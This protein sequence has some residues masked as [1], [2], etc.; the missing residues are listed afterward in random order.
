MT[1]R[2]CIF[3]MH[4]ISGVV[5]G[6][7]V[8]IMSVTGVL[9]TYE[10]QML[11]QADRGSYRTP[12]PHAGASR[13]TIEEVL[14]KV[15][16]RLPRGA[17]VTV[18]SGADEPVEIAAGR[19]G[20]LYVNPWTG[21]VLGGSAD[22][23][24]YWFAKIRA[25]HRWLGAEGESRAAARAITG[26]SNLAFLFLVVSGAYLWIPRVWRWPAVKQVLLFRGG[27]TGKAR[28]FN[29][30]NVLGVWMVVPLFVVVLTAVPISYTWAGNLLYAIAGGSPPTVPG[31]P[32][33]R[34][35]DETRYRLDGLNGM[36]WKAEQQSSRWQGITFRLPERA[37]APVTFTIDEGDGGQPQKRGTLTL[38]A[39]T[40]S[41]VKWEPFSSLE[42]GRRLRMWMRFLHTGEALGP[43]GQTV[44]GVASAAAVVLVYTGIALSVRRWAGWRRRKRQAREVESLVEV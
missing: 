27:L 31:P 6:A 41:V 14:G 13:L 25:W 4:L 32:G 38:N 9:L 42:G 19:E 16:G 20:S 28:D 30:H 22:G 35:G 29:W 12:P 1:F 15:K 5:A 40:G 39:A 10:R 18:R 2:K 7:V 44:A 11:A 26:A 17:S 3:W 37:G 34:Q 43:A 24:R 8:L 21:A 33:G 36:L 23:A